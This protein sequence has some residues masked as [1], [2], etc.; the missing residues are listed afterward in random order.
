MSAFGAPFPF[1]TP[2]L[3]AR[4]AP[5]DGTDQ[6][7]TLSFGLL[8]IAKPSS[9]RRG[10]FLLS[11]HLLFEGQPSPGV[12]PLESFAEK[13]EHDR[14]RRTTS[15]AFVAY[16][17]PVDDTDQSSTVWFDVPAIAPEA[18]HTSTLLHSPHLIFDG[19][20]SPD[21][22]LYT[23]CTQWKDDRNWAVLLQV[24]EEIYAQMRQ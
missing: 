18:F 24:Q 9:R 10:T 15:P 3:V 8:W 21:S 6:S 17:R 5:V 14:S 13:R 1:T 12:Q 2:A 23:V 7:S 20:I 16:D 22:V 19:N 11:L 4:D